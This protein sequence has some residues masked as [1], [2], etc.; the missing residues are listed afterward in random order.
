MRVRLAVFF[1]VGAVGLGLMGACSGAHEARHDSSTAAAP[2]NDTPRLDA[3]GL[4]ALSIDEVGHRLGA[5]RPVP[6]ALRDP[7]LL[8]QAPQ[9]EPLDS[10]ALFHY[11]GLSVVV[12]Y[13]YATRR[14]NDLLLVGDNEDAL[15]SQGHL[16]LGAA[17]YLVLPIFQKSH[18][19]AL[20]G[21]RVLPSKVR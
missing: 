13:N 18:P 6:P 4:L 11:R 2:L 1:S 20:L 21:L 17:D 7:T 8:P 12:S 14:V 16:R 15:M 19:T 9:N 5:P 3:P 10:T